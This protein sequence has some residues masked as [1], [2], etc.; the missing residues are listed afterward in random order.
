MSPSAPISPT[1]DVR[2][3]AGSHKICCTGC[4]YALAPAGQ[5]WKP[6]SIVSEMPTEILSH[7][8]G[9]GEPADTV[10]RLFVCRGCGALLDSETALPKEPF[11]EDIVIT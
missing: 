1:L 3:V 7:E 5:P 4:G 2:E 10:L 8:S 9:T 11:L 6:A